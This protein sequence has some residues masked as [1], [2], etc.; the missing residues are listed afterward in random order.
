MGI[1][2]SI[3]ATHVAS[4]SCV[5]QLYYGASSNFSFLQQIHHCLSGGARS[6]RTN[7]DVQEG[8]AELDLYGQRS[9]FFGTPDAMRRSI[10]HAAH[11]SF[12]LLSE[13]LAECFL[14]DYLSTFQPLLP[15]DSTTGISQKI[16]QLFASPGTSSL[17][18]NDT[19]NLMATLAIGATMKE[20]TG[21]AEMLADKAKHIES[22]MVHVV[23]LQAVQL[24]LLLISTTITPRMNVD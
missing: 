14:A 12:I 6:R 8:G 7:D 11:P 21:W 18:T 22:T 4:T 9:L 10:G 5:L 1:N 24:S 2:S 16:K 17:S 20:D 23:N 15:F 3:S 13:Q 19:G